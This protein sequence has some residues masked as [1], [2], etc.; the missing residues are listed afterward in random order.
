LTDQTSTRGKKRGQKE[1][2]GE[3]STTKS[4]ELNNNKG[5]CKIYIYRAE[6]IFRRQKKEITKGEV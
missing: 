4:E 6:R 5:D 2:L 1:G 3:R